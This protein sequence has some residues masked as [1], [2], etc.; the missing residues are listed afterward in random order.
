[1]SV[2]KRSTCKDL[3]TIQGKATDQYIKKCF[4]MKRII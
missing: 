2:L 1:M 4:D 3:E